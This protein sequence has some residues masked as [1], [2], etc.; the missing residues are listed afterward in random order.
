MMEPKAPRSLRLSEHQLL[1]EA[2]RLL[3]RLAKDNAFIKPLE[4][5]ARKNREYGLFN[6]RN[7]YQ[8]AVLH[9]GSPI[10]LGLQEHALIETSE[11]GFVLSDAGHMWLRRRDATSEPFREQHQSRRV[12]HRETGGVMRPV[13]VNDR[14]SPLSWL[15][16]RKDKGGKPLISLAQYQAGE[17]LRTD[18]ERGQLMPGTTSNWEGRAPSRQQRRAAPEGASELGLS[19]LAARERVTAALAAVGPELAD[20]LLDVCCYL[21][22]LAETEKGHGWPRRSGKIILQIALSRLADHYGLQGAEGACANGRRKRI[23]HWGDADFRPSLD[24]WL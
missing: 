5:T 3:P 7:G 19:A 15:H 23:S 17:K 20:V 14:E 13:V 1:R 18:Y 12:D 22:G 2:T 10:V 9:V 11:N 21:M 6:R 24:A 8:R 16:R 4:D